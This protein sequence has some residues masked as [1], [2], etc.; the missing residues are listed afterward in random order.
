MKHKIE[1]SEKLPRIENV[2]DAVSKCGDFNPASPA[3]STIPDSTFNFENNGPAGSQIFETSLHQ[4]YDNLR[5]SENSNF[6]IMPHQLVQNQDL[7]QSDFVEFSPVYQGVSS[8]ML[9]FHQNLEEQNIIQRTSEITSVYEVRFPFWFGSDA[10]S[11]RNSKWGIS[12]NTI[13]ET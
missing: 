9:K 13:I 3:R 8:E 10:F 1:F 11:Y 5:I 7:G 2:F 12:K 4:L 6:S